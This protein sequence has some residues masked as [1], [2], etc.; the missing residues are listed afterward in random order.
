MV[1]GLFA[2]LIERASDLLASAIYQRILDDRRTGTRQSAPAGAPTTWKQILT[3][4]M[5]ERI[6]DRAE[7][8]ELLGEIRGEPLTSGP[9]VPHKARP[10]RRE[11]LARTQSSPRTRSVRR[12]AA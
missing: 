12:R 8:R 5:Q 6:L 7:A 4:A 9:S 10:R 1:S 11:T 2:R 3:W